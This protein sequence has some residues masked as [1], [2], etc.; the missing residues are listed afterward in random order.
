[1][2]WSESVAI[3]LKELNIVGKCG[4]TE[5][6]ATFTTLYKDSQA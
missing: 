4:N 5:L 6:L 3:L 2:F 1:M